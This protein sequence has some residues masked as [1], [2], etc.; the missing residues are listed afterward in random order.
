MKRLAFSIIE[1]MI[2]FA[3]IAVCAGALVINFQ[4]AYKEGQEKDVANIVESKL[5][6]GAQLAKI[7]GGEVRVVIDEEDGVKYIS[8]DRD[9]NVSSRMKATLSRKTKLPLVRE[10]VLTP[11]NR[12]DI[13]IFFF[14]WGLKTPDIELG[15]L[16]NSGNKITLV[17]A[18][19]VPNVVVD[20]PKVIEDLFPHEIIEDEKE[21]IHVH[22]D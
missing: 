14:P 18:K 6:M 3:I 20:D 1:V 5:R 16:F 15:L 17:P 21:E 7:S 19:Y 4:K 2:A 11:N 8:F 13:A 22:T 12:N 10:V 9:I